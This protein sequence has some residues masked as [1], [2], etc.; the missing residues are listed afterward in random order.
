MWGNIQLLGLQCV[1]PCILTKNRQFKIYVVRTQCRILFLFPDLIFFVSLIMYSFASP[2][3]NKCFCISVKEL[4]LLCTLGFLSLF[5]TA[6]YQ[7][8]YCILCI[9]AYKIYKIKMHTY[10]HIWF[11]YYIRKAI[12]FGHRK[13]MLH[14]LICHL[15]RQIDTCIDM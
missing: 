1:S 13:F 4:S 14:H 8:I 3:E 2:R 9:F 15:I 6:W 7:V 11:V 10:L 5:D 12:L